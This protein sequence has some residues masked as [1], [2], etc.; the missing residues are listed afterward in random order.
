M[1]RTLW[2][3]AISF[4]LVHI[5]VELYSAVK[6]NE[7]DFTMLDRRNLAPVG[8]RRVNK[9]TG[10]EVPWEDI[11][12]GYEYEEGRYVVLSEEDLRLANAKA[13]QTIDITG[14]IDTDSIPPT[15]FDTPYYL[16]PGK[17]GDK[18][19]ALLREALKRTDK[20]A[21]ANIVIHTKQHLAA[22]MSTD[23]LLILNTLRYTAEIRPTD[24]LDVPSHNLKSI[25]INEKEIGMALRLVEEM[26]EKWTPDHYRDT[27][28]EDILA[29]IKKKVKAGQTQKI[30]EAEEVDTKQSSA[31]VIDLMAL[32]KRS[33]NTTAKGR[34][35]PANTATQ[36]AVR[37]KPVAAKRSAK[38][39]RKTTVE[40]R[41]RA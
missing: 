29:Q 17:Q 22:L 12:K 5:P 35:G 7:F 28:R 6:Q 25:G 32:L 39:A 14:F 40:R 41:R 3:G 37:K 23:S 38:M 31:D 21:I 18:G 8:Y 15:Y 19:Y 24:E 11:V 36:P 34:Q 16:A 4:G 30:T 33:I 20:V 13:T 1:A 10:E 27:Y 26:S 9:E 2:K